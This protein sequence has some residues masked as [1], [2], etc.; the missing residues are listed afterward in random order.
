MECTIETAVMATEQPENTEQIPEGAILDPA[1]EE[2]QRQ[3]EAEAQQ[4]ALLAE[5]SELL[6]PEAIADLGDP[7]AIKVALAEARRIREQ[8]AAQFVSAPVA[9]QAPD[10]A[11]EGQ[12]SGEDI[13]VPPED[14]QVDPAAWKAVQ[15]L[16]ARFKAL[17]ASKKAAS[18]N[19][20]DFMFAQAAQML[21]AEIGKGPTSQL[22][23]NSVARA[24]RMRVVANAARIQNEARTANTAVPSDQE[25]FDMALRSVCGKQVAEIEM[26]AKAKAAKERMESISSRPGG[27]RRF[28]PDGPEKA[29]A[30][31]E[32]ARRLRGT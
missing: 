28:L 15:A 26:A 11:L 16:N 2:A 27:A 10:A 24:T 1:F 25:A 19:E 32:Q 9:E 13:A 21:P 20:M 3:V 31:L 18:V 23:M 7:K 30:A 5:A 22:P 14:E 29:L 12:G 8:V 6:S 4:A 17:E